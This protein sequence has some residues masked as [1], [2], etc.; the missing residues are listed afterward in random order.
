MAHVDDT[1]VAGSLAE[2]VWLM[3]EVETIMV[4]NRNSEPVYG[5][6]LS[7]TDAGYT[8][9]SN[10]VYAQNFTKQFGLQE[11]KDVVVSAGAI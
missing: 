1:I 6:E 9:E 11:T 5:R 3:L 4:L 7:Q 8:M 2:L 10:P